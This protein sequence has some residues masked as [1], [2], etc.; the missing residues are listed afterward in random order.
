MEPTQSNSADHDT[1]SIEALIDL[2]HALSLEFVII[3]LIVMIGI[4]VFFAYCCPNF[5]M[6]A[7]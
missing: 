5:I 3:Y 2:V 1:M 4:I 6:D 7:D